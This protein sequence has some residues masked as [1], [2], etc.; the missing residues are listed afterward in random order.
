VKESI[1]NGATTVG[2]GMLDLKHFFDD[3]VDFRSPSDLLPPFNG[4]KVAGLF[5]DPTFDQVILQPDMNE[6]TNPPDGI[7]DI[8]Q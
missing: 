6:D 5:P 8:L 4:N 7:P 3:G 2:Q 1:L